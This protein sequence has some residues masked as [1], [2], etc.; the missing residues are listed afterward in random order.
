MISSTT[1]EVPV[2]EGAEQ[3]G[4]LTVVVEQATNNWCAYT[5]DEIGVIVATAGTREAVIESFRSALGLHLRSMRE[6]GLA[7]PHITRLEVRETMTV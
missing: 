3:S 2:R 5:P 1:L 7:V 4:T 6:E